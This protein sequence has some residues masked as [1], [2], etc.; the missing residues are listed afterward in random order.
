VLYAVAVYFLILNGS[1]R[2]IAI[3]LPLLIAIG[4]VIIT[5][6]RKAHREARLSG[7][8]AGIDLVHGTVSQ[9]GEDRSFPRRIKHLLKKLH[10]NSDSIRRDAIGQLV[11]LGRDTTISRER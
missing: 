3:R 4:A 2:A 1:V 7:P 9:L 5:L 10:S 11:N 6:L 8:L